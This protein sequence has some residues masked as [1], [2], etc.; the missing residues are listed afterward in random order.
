ML[1][2]TFFICVFSVLISL[3]CLCL[4]KLD[5]IC[6]IPVF[7]SL[8]SGVKPIL[9]A[10]LT[11][12]LYL[13]SLSCAEVAIPSKYLALFW[14]SWFSVVHFVINSSFCAILAFRGATASLILCCATLAASST[15]CF[16]VDSA[17]LNLTVFK[18]CF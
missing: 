13:S 2:R 18:I 16:T 6:A 8:I 10:S 14:C 7:C 12:F 5:K 1:V 3:G 15:A 17:I 4:S 9:Y 11:M